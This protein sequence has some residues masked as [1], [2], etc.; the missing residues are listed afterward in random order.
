MSGESLDLQSRL[1]RSHVAAGRLAEARRTIEAALATFGDHANLWALAAEVARREGRFRDAARAAG[2]ACGLDPSNS[3]LELA[4]ATL[5][6]LLGNAGAVEQAVDATL[7]AGASTSEELNALAAALFRCSLQ[8]KALALYERVL[9]DN[10]RDGTALRGLAMTCRAL[11][12]EDR[13]LAS[14]DLALAANPLDGE[15]QLLRSSLRRAGP[16][17]NH[18]AGLRRL[19]ADASLNW[20]TRFQLGYALAKELE[21]LREHTPSFTALKTAADLRRRHLRYDV[22][23]DVETLES[24]AEA[25]SAAALSAL[26]RPGTASDAPVFVLG[27]PRTG[28]TIIERVLSS[29][30]EIDTCGELNSFALEVVERTTLANG[31]AAVPRAAL[32][33]AALALDMHDLGTGYLESTQPM[34]GSGSHFVDKMP[35]NSL[36]I[37]LIHLALPKAK[38]VLTE[39]QAADACYAMYKFPF[40]GAYPF[41]YD[42]QDLALYFAAHQRLMAHWQLV[43][44]SITLMVLRY[45]DLIADPNHEIER[46]FQHVGLAPTPECFDFERNT[47]PSVTGSAIQVRSALHSS[48]IG[49]WRHYEKQLGPLLTT[50]TSAG[51]LLGN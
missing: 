33:R 15:M 24:L 23:N 29:H 7:R 9:K 39:R 37:G 8:H 1:A 12:H 35:M 22:K 45:E 4:R 17:D 16:D 6:A 20:R 11:G 44:P 43:I 48:S 42:L 38:I 34:R 30:P 18:V 28:S 2:T 14:A 26:R 13:A 19:L 41:S 51:V 21:D 49:L 36:Y 32:A 40:S 50:L 47:S 27:L 46:L 10:P 25:F 31:G 5:E 3:T